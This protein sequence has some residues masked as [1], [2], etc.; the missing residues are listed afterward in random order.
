MVV[1]KHNDSITTLYGHNRELLVEVGQ[2][3]Y[4]GSRIALSGNTGLSTAPHLHYEIRINDNPID[5]LDNW[6]D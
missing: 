6:Y 4:A 1:L 5:P 3:V 2:N